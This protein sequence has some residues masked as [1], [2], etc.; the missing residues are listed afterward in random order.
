MIK[1]HLLWNY[2]NDLR[3]DDL[4]SWTS[5]LLFA[6]KRAI[7]ARQRGDSDINICM[8]DTRKGALSGTTFYNAK[9]LLE[10]YEIPSEDKLQHRF[11]TAEYLTLGSVKLNETNSHVVLLEHLIRDGLYNLAPHLRAREGLCIPVNDIR[12]GKLFRQPSELSTKDIENAKSLARNMS[13]TL[14]LAFL[15]ALLSLQ[16]RKEDDDLFVEV[17][18]EACFGMWFVARIH[19]HC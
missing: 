14:Y 3:R 15:I 9:T 12:M 4:T 16:K 13:G 2:D 17:I 5:S 19:N 7:F 18:I 8:V 6:L 11:Y 1:S 10:I